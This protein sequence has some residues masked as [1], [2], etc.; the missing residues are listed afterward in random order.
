M[1]ILKRDYKKTKPYVREIRISCTGID[2]SY[3]DERQAMRFVSRAV[4]V[5]MLQA[6]RSYGDFYPVEVGGA[7]VR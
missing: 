7:D 3:G 2:I 5:H 6:L 1:F 4:A